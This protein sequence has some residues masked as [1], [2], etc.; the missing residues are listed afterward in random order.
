MRVFDDRV[1]GITE[2]PRAAPEA[3]VEFFAIEEIA[4]VE[5]ARRLHIGAGHEHARTADI[6]ERALDRGDIDR[7][8]GR[9][10]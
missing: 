9:S 1:M 4:L 5:L 2:P 6:I 3:P 7:G 8:V 10:A